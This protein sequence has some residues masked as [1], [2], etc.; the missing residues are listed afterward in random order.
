MKTNAER[1]WETDL[2]TWRLKVWAWQWDHN[3]AEFQ[4]V[5]DMRT[6]ATNYGIF[7]LELRARMHELANERDALR[8]SRPIPPTGQKHDIAVAVSQFASS[9]IGMARASANVAEAAIAFDKVWR[10]FEKE[11]GVV[12]E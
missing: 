1:A 2:L 11:F 4:R 6:R 7:P 12:S 10:T 3:V 5:R 9:L 8:A